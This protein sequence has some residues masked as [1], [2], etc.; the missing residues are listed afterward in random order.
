MK[1]S[2]PIEAKRRELTRI[3]SERRAA[4]LRAASGDHANRRELRSALE[5]DA[6]SVERD[7]TRMPEAH[8][9]RVLSY[10]RS[11]T[12]GGGRVW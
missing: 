6:A 11:R 1:A 5:Q 3:I 2:E 7:V 12:Y 4:R 8:L 9:D 10:Y